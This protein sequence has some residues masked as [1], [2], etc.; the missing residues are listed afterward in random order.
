MWG[1]G[2]LF[3]APDWFVAQA[4]ALTTATAARN[5]MTNCTRRSS[6]PMAQWSINR[7]VGAQASSAPR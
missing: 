5:S 1:S 3:P 7:R 6:H 4:G 2:L